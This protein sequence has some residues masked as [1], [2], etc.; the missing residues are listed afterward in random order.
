MGWDS[1]SNWTTKNDVVQSV[2]KDGDVVEHTLRGNTLWAIHKNMSGHIFIACHI[3]E[4]HGGCYSVKSMSVDMH[5]YFYDCPLKYLDVVACD[6]NASGMAWRAKVREIASAKSAK[7]G[8]LRGL[9]PG[10]QVELVAG[11][12]FRG[13]VVS[14]ATVVTA[15]PLVV[16][17]GQDVTKVRPSLIAKVL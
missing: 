12:K 9:T 10:V 13:E 5:P 8:A 3:M 15:K 7:R 11:C 16:R 1:C 17:I 2:L 14:L 4:K 6:G